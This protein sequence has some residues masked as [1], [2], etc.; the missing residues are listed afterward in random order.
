MTGAKS[1]GGAPVPQQGIQTHTLQKQSGKWLIAA[2]QNTN[3][4]PEMPFP[5]GP[6]PSAP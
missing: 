3:A 4:I 1:P 6:P 2:F 5:K